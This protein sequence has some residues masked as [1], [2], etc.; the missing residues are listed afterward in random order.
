MTTLLETVA[1]RSPITDHDGRSGALLERVRLDDGR[2]LVL[3]WLDRSKDLGMVVTGDEMGREHVLWQAG[4]LDRLPA[5]VG[6]AVVQ[7]WPTPTGSAVAMRDISGAMLGWATRIDRAQCRRIL[8]AVTRMHHSF[9]GT[10]PVA[11]AC[12]MGTRIKALTPKVMAAVVESPNPLPRL[13]L[14]GW[15]S[16]AEQAPADLAGPV[17]ML[18][19]EPAPLVHALS[20]LPQTLLHGDVSLPNIALEEQQVTLLDWAL[21]TNGPAEYEVAWFLADSG[22][23]VDASLDE[24]VADYLDLAEASGLQLALLAAFIGL[25]WNKSLN[26]ATHPDPAERAAH[27]DELHWWYGAARDGLAALGVRG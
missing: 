23:L 22:T 14:R 21:A 4:V 26:A 7:T 24:I 6:H 15:E 19:E 5:G 10:G 3:K 13:V 1:E 2:W 20:R 27:L 16:F 25:G 11:G 9:N 8:A 18:L 17:L 12:S